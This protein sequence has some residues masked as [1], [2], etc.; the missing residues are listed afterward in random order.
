[1]HVE[2]PEK[3]LAESTEIDEEVRNVVHDEPDEGE[4]FEQIVYLMQ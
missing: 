3:S 4:N 1:M 2:D